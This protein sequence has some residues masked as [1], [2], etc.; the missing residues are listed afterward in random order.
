MQAQSSQIC[1]HSF[2][3]EPGSERNLSTVV[4]REMHGSFFFERNGRSTAI[5]FKEEENYKVLQ[6]GYYIK[7]ENPLTQLKVN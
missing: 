6:M 4:L 7:T 1:L 3:Y 2:R 5:S